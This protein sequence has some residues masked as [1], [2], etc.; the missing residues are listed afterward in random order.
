MPVIGQNGHGLDR[1][2]SA[3]A[4]R[5]EGR[6]QIVNM[7]GQEIPMAFQNRDREKKVPP[8]SKERRYCGMILV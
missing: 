7:A 1:E 5:Y 3:L 2:G 4:G 6:P 8:G